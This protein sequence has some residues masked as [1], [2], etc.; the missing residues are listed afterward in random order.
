MKIKIKHWLASST[1]ETESGQHFHRKSLLV[2]VVKQ[3]ENKW[4][5]YI[6][7]ICLNY[8][9]KYPTRAKLIITDLIVYQ[10]IIAVRTFNNLDLLIGEVNSAVRKHLRDGFKQIVHRW[11][12]DSLLSVEDVKLVEHDEDGNIEFTVIYLIDNDKSNGVIIKHY[13]GS[14]DE[15]Q[16]DAYRRFHQQQLDLL[17]RFKKEVN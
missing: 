3:I 2:Q 4:K 11:C 5:N 14:I 17:N 16:V 6:R 1:S 13:I 10:S 9:E 8:D 15:N 12:K 7:S